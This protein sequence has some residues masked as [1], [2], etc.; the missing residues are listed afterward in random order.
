MTDKIT[1]KPYDWQEPDITQLV[2]LLSENGIAADLSDP[3]TG[4]MYKAC[5]VAKF[6]KLKIA[7]VCPK[8]I[9]AAW[10]EVAAKVRIEVVLITNYERLRMGAT[11]LGHWYSKR[12]FVWTV[13]QDCLVVVDECHRAKGHDTQNCRMVMAL[14]DCGVCALLL[15]ATAAENPLEMKA[16]GYV[17]RLHDG[18]DFIPFCKDLGCRPG[19][20]GGHIYKGG[21]EGLIRLSELIA[22]RVVRTR[23]RDLGERF[24]AN[25]VQTLPLET[26]EADAID[27]VILEELNLLVSGAETELVAGLRARQKAEYLK[28]KALC[29]MIQDLVAE[30]RS[31][32][33]FV[34]FRETLKALMPTAARINGEGVACAIIGGQS[35]TDRQAAIDAFQDDRARVILCMIQAGGVGLSLHDIHGNYPR[36]S[37]ICPTFS[38]IDLKQALGRIHRAGAKSSAQQMIIFAAGTIEEQVRAKVEAKIANIDLLNDGDLALSLPEKLQKKSGRFEPPMREIPIEDGTADT[39]EAVRVNKTETEPPISA[40]VCGETTMRTQELSHHETTMN[41]TDINHSE[42]QHAPLSPSALAYFERCPG[43]QKEDTAE[44]HP[45][46]LL[47]TAMHEAMESG[48]SDH[49]ELNDQECVALCEEFLTSLQEV[50]PNALIQ[51]EVQLETNFPDIYGTCDWLLVDGSQAILVDFK[52]GYNLVSEPDEN[53]QAVA[54]SLGIFLRESQVQTVDF[55]FLIPRCDAVLHHQ[56]KRSDVPWMQLRL[57]T[58]RARVY[59]E[60]K[61]YNPQPGLCEYC[62]FRAKCPA[63][64]NKVLPLARKY[65]GDHYELPVEVHSSAITDPADMSKALRLAHLMDK[66]A[67][68]VKRHALAMRLEQGIEI[69]GFELA[70]RAGKRTVTDLLAAWEIT[71][72]AGV[73]LDAFLTA[74]DVS[75]TKLQEVYAD[76]APPRKKKAWKQILADRLT[77]REAITAGAPIRYLKTTKK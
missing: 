75:I 32:A 39:E 8:S 51:Q 23:I 43:Y 30:R 72:E 18:K 68:S 15:S 57:E 29:Q 47:G 63:L 54:Y 58:I 41:K 74:C 1:I 16:L 60:Q 25:Q 61:D 49:L 2:K 56:F 3:G 37:L 7:V 59:A 64:L 27:G 40:A 28:A 66:W 35:E 67:D 44:V 13:P 20:F 17:L 38:A 24:P 4:K 53:P 55:Y 73:T 76:K 69:P 5:F 6:A 9:R 33:V 26:D 62:G 50:R 34:A 48:K 71:Q 10:A 12:K 11:P 22:P 46:T 70:E 45:V 42:R 65:Q 19:P 52:F 36:V 77:D 31:V 21:P 14:R